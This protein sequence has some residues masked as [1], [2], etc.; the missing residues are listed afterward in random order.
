MRLYWSNPTRYLCWRTKNDS[1][2]RLRDWKNVSAQHTFSSRGK[3]VC[4]NA[5]V[6][7]FGQILCQILRPVCFRAVH[8][9]F[10]CSAGV[11]WTFPDLTRK[12][13]FPTPNCLE[14]LKKKPVQVLPQFI[15]LWQTIVRRKWK[16]KS[17]T[18]HWLQTLFSQL[19]DL[20]STPTQ[21]A[22]GHKEDTECYRL[23]RHKWGGHLRLLCLS[24]LWQC[25]HF[26]NL[27][28]TLYRKETTADLSAVNTV[29][30]RL[31]QIYCHLTWFLRKNS[32]Y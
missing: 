19:A 31:P 28:A 24:D 23:A 14:K 16:L 15:I 20:D 7:C 30:H 12:Q 2:L 6:Q 32:S 11:D 4:K 1:R 9:G 26:W 21:K 5:L 3:T 17:C 27:F 13:R 25:A 22:N 29:S 18:E 8:W 10:S